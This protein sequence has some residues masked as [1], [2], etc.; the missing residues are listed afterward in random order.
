[1]CSSLFR[2]AYNTNGN[3]LSN[4]I[5]NS[6]VNCN[7]N[8]IGNSKII[9]N[10]NI[11]GNSNISCTV[12]LAVTLAVTVTLSVTIKYIEDSKKNYMKSISELFDLLQTD[13]HTHK[14][15]SNYWDYV[16]AVIK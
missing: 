11:R 12:T 9:S 10:S 15:V 6:N 8:I 2:F 3:S 14:L 4:I 1:M 5:G 13:I 7:S 16:L